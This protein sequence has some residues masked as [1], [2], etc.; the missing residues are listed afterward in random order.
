MLRQQDAKVTTLYLPEECSLVEERAVVESGTGVR[1][2]ME[3]AG[4]G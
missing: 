1:A 2:V 4:R 3:Q